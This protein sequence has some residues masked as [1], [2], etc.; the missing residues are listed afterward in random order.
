MKIYIFNKMVKEGTVI[1][2]V[3]L[4]F[5]DKILR[6]ELQNSNAAEAFFSIKNGKPISIE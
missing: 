1:A 6:D 3:V 2:D 4:N 5:D